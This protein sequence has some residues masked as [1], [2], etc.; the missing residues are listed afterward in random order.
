MYPSWLPPSTVEAAAQPGPLWVKITGQAA[1]TNRYAW[2]QIDEGDT[3]AFDVGLAGEFAATGTS[4]ADGAPTYEINGNTAVPVG[5]RVR[6]WPAGDQTYYVFEYTAGAGSGPS[7][8]PAAVGCGWA[9]ALRQ[10]D[11]LEVTVLSA[12]GACDC[13]DPPACGVCPDGSPDTWTVVLPSDGGGAYAGLAGTYTLTRTSGCVWESSGWPTGPSWR[14]DNV[15]FG[16]GWFL[17]GTAPSGEQV[18]FLISS[19]VCCGPN[20]CVDQ[21]DSDTATY[22]GTSILTLTAGGP[23]PPVA[24]VQRSVL[25]SGDGA[26]WGASAGS[27]G[28]GGGTGLVTDCVPGACLGATAAMSWLGSGCASGPLPTLTRSGSTPRWVG[29]DTTTYAVEC[30]S[31][32]WVA[33]RDTGGGPVVASYLTVLYDAVSIEIQAG[34]SDGACTGGQRL[35]GF[36]IPKVSCGA[37][38][39]GEGGGGGTASAPLVICGASYLPSFTKGGCDGPCLTLAPAGGAGSGSGGTVYTGTRESC[40][41]NWAVFAFGAPAICTG[42]RACGGPAA[43]VLRVRVSWVSCLWAG[44]G[45]YCVKDCPGTTCAAVELLEGDQ[46]RTD[47]EICS[48]PYVNE[49]AAGAVCPVLSPVYASCAEAAAAPPL[50]RGVEYSFRHTFDGVNP[51]WINLGDWAPPEVI[52]Y[53]TWNLGGPEDT[54]PQTEVRSCAG[55]VI[56]SNVN[57]T[58][59]YDSV[60]KLRCLANGLS[61]YSGNLV[62]RIQAY[63]LADWDFR[64]TVDNGSC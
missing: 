47:I 19:F 37:S 16:D 40:G 63:P 61:G 1:G 2:E 34:W 8:G 46:Y 15:S 52:R 5:R 35:Y 48:G 18:F 55:S 26:T 60:T 17:A 45:W 54:S 36:T 20:A 11:C 43:N 13:P 51:I 9:A 10:P 39:G 4:A 64:I 22:S 58:T 25:T 29:S 24:P 59:P 41:P 7:T 38:A 27:G 3:A 12:G 28:G 56:S 49:A 31:G 30:V 57:S 53:Q 44:P 62:M 42:T 50:T 33:T 32:S 23:C 6:I 21:P 14:L